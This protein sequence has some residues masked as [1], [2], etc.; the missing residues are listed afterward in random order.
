MTNYD[1]NKPQKGKFETDDGTITIKS[2]LRAKQFV[3]GYDLPPFVLRLEFNYLKDGENDSGFFHYR[4]NWYHTRDFMRAKG[5]MAKLGWSGVLQ[6]TYS[7]GVLIA[8]VD[9]GEEYIV[10]TFSS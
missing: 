9:D 8:L 5:L 4:G 3:S 6:N 10:G 1:D 7:S 2:D